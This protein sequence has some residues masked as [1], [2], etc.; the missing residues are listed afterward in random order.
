M[1]PLIPLRRSKRAAKDRLSKYLAGVTR[2]GGSS[3]TA[4]DALSVLPAMRSYPP[5]Q[6]R[7]TVLHK[8]RYAKTEEWTAALPAVGYNETTEE[9]RHRDTVPAEGRSAPQPGQQEKSFPPHDIKP[10][11]NAEAQSGST[12]RS[13]NADLQR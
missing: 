12:R 5:L 3:Y 8:A 6:G 11:R 1:Q 4:N 10:P 13:R 9:T 7:H 2:K